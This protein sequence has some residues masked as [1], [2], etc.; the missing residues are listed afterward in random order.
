M[1][2]G[3]WGW[4]AGAVAGVTVLHGPAAGHRT[5]PPPGFT[6]GFGEP[7]CAQ[8][9]EGNEVNAFGGWV[10][11]EGLPER[12]QPG[13]RYILTV[14]L[15]ADE[16]AAAG[17]QLAAR[18]AQPPHTGAPAGTLEPLD[19]RVALN[20]DPAGRRYAQHT[21]EGTTVPSSDGASWTLAW[22]APAGGQDAVLVHVAANSAN[23]DNSPL[24][25]LIYTAAV[26][27]NPTR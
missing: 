9:H 26:R 13:E 4:I 23:G 24:G 5:G 19:G 3:R 8:C 14:V 21:E 12:Y 18:F 11:I 6:G 15:R 25:D 1:R 27:V 22:T 17:F 16:T 20:T 7:T 10:R 2:S